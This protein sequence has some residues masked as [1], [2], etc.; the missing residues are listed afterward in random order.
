MTFGPIVEKIA[1]L[2]EEY[3]PELDDYVTK[4]VARAQKEWD[5]QFEKDYNDAMKAVA[6]G[7]STQQTVQEHIKWV[8]SIC[9]AQSVC[10]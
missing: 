5:E 1:I 9:G 10:N 7:Q 2:P 6:S 4:L 8:E 3:L